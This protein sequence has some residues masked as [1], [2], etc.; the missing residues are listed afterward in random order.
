MGSDRVTESIAIV[1]MGCRFPGRITSP[2]GFW[3]LLEEG[4]AVHGEIPPGRWDSYAARGPEYARAVRGAIRFGGYLEDVGAF[5]AGFFGISPREAELMDPQQRVTLEVAWEALEDAGIPASVLAGSDTGV[6]MGV[7]TDDYGRRILEDLPRLEAWAGIGNSMCGVANRVSYALDLRGPSIVVDTA[8]SASLV[9]VHQACQALRLGETSLALAGGVMLVT[10]PS[11]A[12]VLDAAG[13]LSRDGRSK[14][15][16]ASADGYGRAEGCA[17]VVLK[18]LSDARRDGDP[19]LAVIRGS[20]VCQDGR[21]NGIMAPSRQAQENLIRLACRNAGLDA[22]DLDYVEAHGTG[23]GIGDPIEAGALAAVVGAGRPPDRPCLIGSVKTNIG[24]LEAASG[25]AG[26][27]KSVLALEHGRI[28]ATLSVTGPNPAIPWAESGLKVVNEAVPW[29]AGDR[30]RRAGIGNYGYGGTLAHVILEEAPPAE[31]AAG[32]PEV[33]PAVGPRV[34]PLSG[35]TPTGVRENAGRLAERVV[36][37]APSLS[38][39]GHTLAHRRSMLAARACVVAT[40]GEQLAERLGRF[41]EGRAAA[42]VAAG[43]VLRGTPSP[44]PVWVFSGHGSQWV[45]MGR[46]LLSSEPLL[47]RTLDELEPIYLKEMGFAPRRALM[48]DDLED[49]D[50]VQAMIF[51]MQVGLARVWRG[52]GVRPAAIIGHSV[53]EVAAA[54]VAGMLTLPDAARLICRRSLLLRRVAGKGAMAMVNLPFDEVEARLAER[55]DVGPAIAAAP[56]STV[57]S[58]TIC[59]MEHVVERFRSEGL[60]VRRVDSDVAFHSADMDGLMSDLVDAVTE[61]RPRPPTVPVFGTALEDPRDGAPRDGAYWAANL[62]NPV[63]F[64]AAVAAAMK[65]G[66]RLFLEVSP[67]PVVAHSIMKTLEAG[68]VPDGVVAH[69]LRRERSE[70]ET[71]LGNLGM[72][73]CHGAPV[74]WSVLQPEGDLAELPTMAWQHRRYWVE[75]T[76]AVQAARQGHDVES[77]DLLGGRVAVQGASPVALWQTRLDRESRPYPGGHAVLGA[78]VVPAAVLLT[79]FLGA[80]WESPRAAA[81]ADVSLRVPLAVTAPRDVQVVRQDGSLRLSSRLAGRPDDGAWL[82]HAT[83]EAVDPPDAGGLLDEAALRASCPEAVDPGAVLER[84]TAID[85]DGLGFPW[86]VTEAWRSARTLLARIVADPEGEMSAATWGSLLDGALSAAPVI[87]PGGPLLRMPGRFREVVAYGPPPDEALVAVRLVEGEAGEDVVVDVRI[88]APDGVVAASL[89]G[90]RFGVVRRAVT[91]E[92]GPED[93]AAREAGIDAGREWLGLEGR[94]LHDHLVGVVGGIVADELRLDSD[95]PSPHRP[96]MDM[97]VDSMLS[98]AIRVRL[99]RRF[100]IDLPSTL[101]WDR[102]TVA[103]I[104]DHLAESLGAS[105]EAAG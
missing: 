5:D 58:G 96:L 54:V 18:R 19:V 26:M 52:Y 63:R 64:A 23:T 53:G 71:L 103:A 35:A 95:A 7:C 87:F 38:S 45:G 98:E 84:L 62:R 40:G 65:D 32:T 17:V 79:T 21:T 101:L 36:A 4:R 100:R 11:F 44:S 9:A 22:S 59:A 89:S 10:S 86:R 83:A 33:Q 20:A 77:H 74:D 6:F 29:P 27:I 50:R 69:T 61:I 42:G 25:V 57:L 80:R 82:V 46:D 47:A 2:R 78:E 51:A 3:D 12:L 49:V 75:E 72:L 85:V 37:D 8:C 70:R 34:Y 104:S 68:G 15:F 39:I 48:E 91:A 14:A 31:A 97:G 56:G 13:A 67:H 76:P 30:P 93:D 92:F 88:A 41:A 90:V 16:D 105:E 66:H 73:H 43:E 1:G 102:P 28:P 99:R 60:V 55:L 81:L 94:D 24:H